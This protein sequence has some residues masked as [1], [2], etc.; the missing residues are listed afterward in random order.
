[1]DENKLAKLLTDLENAA[2]GYNECYCSIGSVL[3]ARLAICEYA[4]EA[5]SYGYNCALL[6]Q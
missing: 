1:V 5:E 2:I 4:K 3:A 6:E